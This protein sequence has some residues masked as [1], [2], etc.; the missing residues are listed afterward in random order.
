M[1]SEELLSPVA[2]L[3]PEPTPP[4]RATILVVD[5]DPDQLET[6]SLRLR[7]QGFLTHSAQTGVAALELADSH[8]PD[9]IL[10]DL[11]LPDMNGLDVCAALADGDTTCSVPIIIVSATD[12]ADAV[13]SSRAAGS[14][15]FVR[16]PYDPNALLTLIERA[17]GHE[18]DL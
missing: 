6:L 4:C 14:T 9:L 11:G 16:K 3:E 10:L 8:R 17:L 2:Q 15:F 13:R 12:S 7:N 18:Y 1:Y 5:D